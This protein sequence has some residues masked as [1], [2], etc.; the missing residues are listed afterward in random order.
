VKSMRRLKGGASYKSKL[1]C[2]WMRQKLLEPGSGQ[3]GCETKEGIVAH[4]SYT[5]S[6]KSR[7]VSAGPCS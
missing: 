1:R 6:L 7:L 2:V 3:Q 4:I 5:P